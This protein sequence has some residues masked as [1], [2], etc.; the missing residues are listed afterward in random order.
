MPSSYPW[1]APLFLLVAAQ[2]S[3]KYRSGLPLPISKHDVLTNVVCCSSPVEEATV[4]AAGDDGSGGEEGR[5]RAVSGVE[6]T[7]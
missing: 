1:K 7:E 5:R 3:S 2:S 4:Q 6:A